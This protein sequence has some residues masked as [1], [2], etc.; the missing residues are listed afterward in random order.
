MKSGNYIYD[1]H[2]FQDDDWGKIKLKDVSEYPNY[3]NNIYMTCTVPRIFC[4]NINHGWI[5]GIVGLKMEY[6]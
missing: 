3:I 1:L 4:D 6:I 5:Q 2:F